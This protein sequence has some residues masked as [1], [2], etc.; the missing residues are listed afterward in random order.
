MVDFSHLLRKPAGEAKRPPALPAGDYEGVIRSYE[1]GDNNR[2]HTPYVR[3]QIVLTSWPQA[4]PEGSRPEGVELSKRQLRKD[5]YLT[6]DSLWRLDTM[7]S[8]CGIEP[9]GRNYE[10][11][12][13]E[14]VGQPVTAEVQ[15]YLNQQT[16]EIGNNIG[17]VVGL[18]GR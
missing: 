8:S 1:F 11:V 4:L 2:N 6:E 16:N 15:Q 13:A 18:N 9:Y 3:F 17:N 10:E 14:M 12:L 7:I 5:A